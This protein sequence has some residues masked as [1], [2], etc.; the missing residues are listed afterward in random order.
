MKIFKK[1]R[2]CGIS[3]SFVKINKAIKIQYKVLKT[4]EF[5]LLITVTCGFLTSICF[6]C[7]KGLEFYNPSFY[8]N[9][10]WV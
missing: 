5:Q 3:D 2:K 4:L 7:N 1:N 8:D 10:F 9:W 6:R